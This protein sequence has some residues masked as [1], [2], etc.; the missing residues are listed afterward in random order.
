MKILVLCLGALLAGC[1][2]QLNEGLAI[3]QANSQHAV[4]CAVDQT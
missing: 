1:S 2:T 4:A 3:R